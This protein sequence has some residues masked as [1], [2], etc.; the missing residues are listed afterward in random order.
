MKSMITG[1]KLSWLFATIYFASYVTRINFAAVVSEV[2]RDTGFAKSTLST[3]LVCM[4]I[5]YGV[6]Q[7]I[8]G[9]IGDK[10]KPQNLIFMGLILASAINFAFPFAAFSV[11]LMCVLWTLNGFAQAMMWPPIVKIMA[12]T[13]DDATYGAGMVLV[14]LGSSVGTILVYL[15]APLIINFSSWRGVMWSAAA[16]GFASVLLWAFT[17]G[18]VYRE[19]A[20]VS[21]PTET[22]TRPARFSL[23]SASI[24]P[25]I[26]I[27][28]ALIFQGMLRDSVTSW[29]PSYL[30]EVFHLE[31]SVGIFCTVSLAIFSMIAFVVAGAF[32]KKFFR[33][34]VA[35]AAVIYG[36]AFLCA[37][38]LCLLFGAGAV[39]AIVLM[40]LLVGCVHGINLML[41][42]H[43]PKRFRAYG[44]LSTISGLINSCVYVGSA[45]ATYAVAKISEVYGWRMTTLSWAAMAGLGGLCTWAAIRGWKKFI[46]K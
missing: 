7:I 1:K 3:I 38:A 18:R 26:F 10:I 13:M 11:P 46:E 30:S 8:N 35:C 24:I 16:I 15:V 14:S 20:E 4:S 25:L 6:G 5:S 17:K 2:V 34:E 43:A 40:A 42:M 41:V 22:F 9:R 23:P 29:M 45:I 37:G 21:T 32:Y 33:N 31:E 28:F 12:A 27:A 44:N 39:A 19:D 36:A